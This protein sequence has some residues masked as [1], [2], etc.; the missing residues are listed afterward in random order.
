MD[1]ELLKRY[2]DSFLLTTLHRFFST[3]KYKMSTTNED[4]LKKL[5]QD[6][7]QSMKKTTTG[8]EGTLFWCLNSFYQTWGIPYANFRNGRASDGGNVTDLNNSSE[9]RSPRKWERIV[10]AEACKGKNNITYYLKPTTVAPYILSNTI[11]V[12][13]ISWLLSE[14]FISIWNALINKYKNTTIT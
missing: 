2:H 5:Y 12:T 10:F 14:F 13:H 7:T 9:K 11:N 4:G 3:W 8:N 6:K 1:L